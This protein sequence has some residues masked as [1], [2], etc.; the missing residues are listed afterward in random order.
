MTAAL[1]TPSPYAALLFPFVLSL[2][3]DAE[4]RMPFGAAPRA[5]PGGFATAARA[6]D[7]EAA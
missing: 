6:S 2:S 7:E 5:E 4:R 3:K 1:F